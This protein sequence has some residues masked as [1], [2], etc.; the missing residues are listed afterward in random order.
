MIPTTLTELRAAHP[1]LFYSQ[2]WYVREAFM[3]TLSNELDPKPPTH[4]RSG[5]GPVHVLLPLAVD[6][7]AAFVRFPEH[8]AWQR[9]LWCRDTDDEGR[10]IYVG[11]VSEKNGYRFEIHRHL[12]ITEQW[13]IPVWT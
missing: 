13:G 9:Y 6:V 4:V 11:G 12:T 8:P 2:D 5:D 1:T 7:A 3:R 10:R